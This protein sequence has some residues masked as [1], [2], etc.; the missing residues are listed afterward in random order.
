[1]RRCTTI[2]T[3]LALLVLAA[4]DRA[5]AHGFGIRYDIPVPFWLYAYGAAAAV[6]L[7][8]VLLVD[9][10][11]V[12]HRYPRFD[13]LRVGWF[14][15]V[16]AGRPFLLGLRLL[17][18]A[19][20]SLIILS[21]LLGDQTPTAN[22]AP[23]FVWIVWWVGLAFLTALVGNLWELV[24]PW[25]ILFEWADGLGK[26]LEPYLPY[27]A[28]WGVWPALAL[29]FGFAW[30][31]LVFLGSARPSNIAVLALLYS[32]I[33]GAASPWGSSMPLLSFRSNAAP[34]P[35]S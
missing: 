28:G 1:M 16:F 6:V 32:A 21:G 30:V 3:L 18:V 5:F 15:A 27:P 17:A 25:K 12:P 34:A 23:T 14:R 33:T 31:E 13:L 4:P 10:K 22:F 24:N 26:G 2:L 11:P 19:I 8:F 9:T 20:F 35:C 29:Y 7:T